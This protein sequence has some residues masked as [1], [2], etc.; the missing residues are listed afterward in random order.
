MT[1]QTVIHTKEKKMLKVT[2][3]LKRWIIK[4]DFLKIKYQKE[5]EFKE[6]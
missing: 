2:K 6:K 1:K 4:D 3:I 5:K